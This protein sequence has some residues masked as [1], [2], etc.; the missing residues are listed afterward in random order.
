MAAARHGEAGALAALYQAHGRAVY[1]LAYR[2]TGTREDAEDVVHDSCV[3][4]P[5]AQHAPALTA[6]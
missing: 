5:A 2:L 4:K 3:D 1:R 6:R